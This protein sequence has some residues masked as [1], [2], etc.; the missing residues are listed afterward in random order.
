L[1]EERNAYK[2]M[3][4]IVHLEVIESGRCDNSL[5][6][7][8]SVQSPEPSIAILASTPFCP[9]LMFADASGLEKTSNVNI[10]LKGRSQY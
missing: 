7:E 5:I 3:G 4:K 8:K 2:G 6:T 1:K 9:S 10:E